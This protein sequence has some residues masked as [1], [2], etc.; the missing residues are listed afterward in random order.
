M[1]DDIRAGLPSASSFG[2]DVSCP[3]RRNLIA[4]LPQV[5]EPIDPDAERGIKIHKAW[6][7]GNTLEL[8]EDEFKDY[9]EGL[10]H[11]ESVREEWIRDKGI[12]KWEELEREERLWLFNDNLEKIGSG[13]I[14][15]WYMGWDEDGL[16][17]VL[18]IDGKSGFG[19]YV[20]A[21]QRSWQLRYYAVCVW[22]ETDC[23][24]IRVAYVK[25]KMKADPTD[26]TDYNP[27][28]LSQ[29]FLSIVHHTWETT[30]PDA[31]R[32][33]GTHCRYCPA[34]KAAR[35]PEA[36]AWNMLPSVVA[37][38]NMV[39][40]IG[41]SITKDEAAALVAT[42]AL[43]DC[44]KVWRGES[45][46]H[47]IENA[48]KAR[49]KAESDETLSS[50]GLGRAK[51]K[52]IRT[53][54]NVKAAH[55]RLVEKHNITSDA[56]FLALKFVNEELV[57]VIRREMGMSAEGAVQFIKETLGEFTDEKEATP[58]LKEL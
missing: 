56:V 1:S 42:L 31:H 50:L 20:P 52:K 16:I 29:S 58:A 8:A 43:A 11:I 45:V 25:P 15:R 17:Y 6:Q 51:A 7:T 48:I 49:L 22:K 19:T 40:V 35:C 4:R 53:I 32:N 27:Y 5:E 3:G 44:V 34:M 55:D 36:A 9:N 26:W 21:S 54:S 10:K 14:D 46:R 13:Q 47:A 33:P 39:A 38:E 37:G 2:T 23:P 30:V 57:M 12:V 18:V 41:D 24:R 28:H